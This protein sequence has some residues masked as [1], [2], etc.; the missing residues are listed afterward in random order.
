MSEYQYYEFQ[1]VDRPLTQ[2]QMAEL[3]NYSSRAQI[4]PSSFV[5]VYNWGSFKGDPDKW[6]EKYFDAFLY[7][8]NWGSHWFMLRV[9]ARLLDPDIA[10]TYCAEENL[11]RRTK[12]DHLILSFHSEEED[13]DEPVGGEGWLGSLVPLRA[14]LMRGDHRCLYLGWLLGAQGGELDDETLEPLVP[15]GLGDLNAPLCCFADFL[16]IDR[17]LIAA[18]AEQ[19]DEG[20]ASGLSKKDIAGWVADLSA[21]DRDAVLTRILEGEDPHTVAELRHCALRDIRGAS[22]SG[23]G[24]QNSGRRNVGELLARAEE[25]T[26]KRR[27]KEA[28]QRAL[29]KAK[30][31]RERAARRKKH[32]ESLIGKEDGLWAEVDQLIATRQPKRYDEAVCLLQDIH[33]LAD[34][35]GRISEFS[36]RMKALCSEHTK[37]TTLAERLRKA[38]LMG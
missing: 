1:A 37:K 33:D 10:S 29:E 17:D 35:Q 18:A 31:E 12:G 27:K 4:T 11:S 2:K 6:M 38:K 22:E 14:E 28:E 24:A 34:M 7:L 9:P 26:G 15:P 8:A 36:L 16:R 30:R 21:K 20:P 23:S 19:S 5:N 25:I 3:R 13:D 32:L